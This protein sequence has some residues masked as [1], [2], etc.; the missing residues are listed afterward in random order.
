MKRILITLGMLLLATG[1]ALGQTSNAGGAKK[2][3]K[4]KP[5][6]VDCS[7]MDDGALTTAVKDKLANAPSLKGQTI[8]VAVSG[9]AV[10]LTGK[11]KTAS[12]K[13]T[14]TRVAKAVKCVKSVTNKLEYDKPVAAPKA[15]GAKKPKTP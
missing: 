5:P 10:T 13:G 2:P 8:D 15:S 14:A 4:P 9:G 1:L 11:V 7:K 12:N 6:A 3:P